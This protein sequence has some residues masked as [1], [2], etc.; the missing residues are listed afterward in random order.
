MVISFLQ[1]RKAIGYLGLALP[2]VLALGNMLLDKPGIQSSL[3]SYYHTS[4]R[5]VFVGV[6]CAIAVFM[7]S[8]RGFDPRDDLVSTLAGTFAVGV[9]LLATTPETDPVP[10]QELVGHIHLMF[11][12]LF[13]ITLAYMCLF[14]FLS[15]IHI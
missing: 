3:S 1:L 2:F 11:A 8:Y 12:A 9:A 4:M 15:L 10:A 5:D 14:L 7:I 6:L 13:F